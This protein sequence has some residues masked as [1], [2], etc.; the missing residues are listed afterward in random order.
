[1]IKLSDLEPIVWHVTDRI[2]IK[3]VIKGY[4]VEK[5]S[6]FSENDL[7]IKEYDSEHMYWLPNEYNSKY[8]VVEFPSLSSAIEAINLL[9]SST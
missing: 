6:C 1:M 9:E 3:K 7:I 2:T 4:I 5:Y 8:D